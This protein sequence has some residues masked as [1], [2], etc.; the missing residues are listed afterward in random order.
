MAFQQYTAP[1]QAKGLEDTAFYRDHTVI[2]LNEVGGDPSRFG[3]SPAEFHEANA[4]RRAE[5]P[6]GM[7]ATATHDTKLGEDTRLRIHTL[8]ELANDWR[9]AV[10]RW[11]RLTASAR[12]AL[13]DG[14]APE[15]A[16]VYRFYQALIGIWPSGRHT[17]ENVM[18][19]VAARLRAYMLKALR[20]AKTR[21]S[22]MH[23]NPAYEAAVEAYVTR[24]LTGRNARR[25]LDAVAPLAERA[26]GLGALYSLSQ[27]VLKLTSPGVA[28][29]YQGTEL[30]ALTLVDPDNRGPVDFER[31]DEAIREL[32][33]ALDGLEHPGARAGV[34]ALQSGA[35]DL[36]RTWRDGRI[37]L[38]V[39]AAGLRLRRAHRELFRRGDYLPLEVEPSAPARAVAFARR[40]GDT[41]LIAVVPRL[42]AAISPRLDP[43]PAAACTWGD[44]RVLIPDMLLHGDSVNVLTGERVRPEHRGEGRSS[45]ALSSLFE[46]FPVAWLWT[47]RT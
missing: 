8:T 11:Q 15:G 5:W 16:D 31:R 14:W 35:R 25:F 10:T 27:V 45:I 12:R 26:A 37:K 21:T 3:R 34:T 40:L 32:A 9:V 39:T 30:W 24:A 13:D 4:A 44:S 7:L 29:A 38:Y 46:N 28:D 33:A 18:A 23:E 41:A 36:A 1:V 42:V 2:S 20:E 22:W 6:D 43:G 19:E 17:D 47:T